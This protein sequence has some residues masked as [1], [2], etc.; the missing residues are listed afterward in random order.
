MSNTHENRL[1]VAD[2]SPLLNLALIG[3]LDLVREQFSTVTITARFAVVSDVKT[4]QH[5]LCLAEPT[6]MAFALPGDGTSR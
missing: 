1:V 3:Q 6:V 5:Q 2:T 4:Q